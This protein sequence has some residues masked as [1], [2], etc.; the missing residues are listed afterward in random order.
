MEFK[1]RKVLKKERSGLLAIM[2]IRYLLS[3]QKPARV[4]RA[5]YEAVNGFVMA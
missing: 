2:T 3:Q 1:E 4:R 5:G